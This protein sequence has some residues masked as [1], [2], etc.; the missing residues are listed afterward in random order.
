MHFHIAFGDFVLIDLRAELT[1]FHRDREVELE[2]VPAAPLGFQAP[3]GG[4]PVEWSSTE[5]Q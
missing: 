2:E 4:E 3:R 1:L 5:P